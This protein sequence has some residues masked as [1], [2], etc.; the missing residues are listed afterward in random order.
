MFVCSFAFKA[1]SF[2]VALAGPEF[3]LQMRLA[4]IQRSACLWLPRTGHRCFF[5]CFLFVCFTR[6]WSHCIGL[7]VQGLREEVGRRI[8]LTAI[9][10]YMRSRMVRAVLT[11]D[12]GSDP[13]TH[14]AADNCARD[15]VY[16]SDRVSIRRTCVSRA[17]HL[18]FSY[19]LHLCFPL[20]IPVSIFLSFN[21][22]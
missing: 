3:T 8:S 5:V 1:G 16:S 6:L 21:T 11:E 18:A 14:T 19:S 12:P 17:E 20:H 4:W 7:K 15:L 2:C 13:S 22:Q 9:T 10:I